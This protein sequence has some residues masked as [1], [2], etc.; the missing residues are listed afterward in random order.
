MHG[1]TD[2]KKACGIPL[3]RDGKGWHSRTPATGTFG[4][5]PGA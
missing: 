2:E 3:L 5:E 1:P 4:P